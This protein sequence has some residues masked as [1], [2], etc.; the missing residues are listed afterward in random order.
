[1]TLTPSVLSFLF[2]LCA[3]LFPCSAHFSFPFLVAPIDPPL[4]AGQREIGQAFL[5]CFYVA[6]FMLC[7]VNVKICCANI[8]CAKLMHKY[9]VQ[10]SLK[11]MCAMFT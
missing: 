5:C 7:K 11:N 4:R 3:R 2:V 8:N 6:I 10:S 9:V 1:M